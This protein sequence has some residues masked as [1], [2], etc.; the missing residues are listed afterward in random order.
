MLSELGF[1]NGDHARKW[2][3][4]AETVLC[5]D[6]WNKASG[7]WS[8]FG[9]LWGRMKWAG[10]AWG[11]GRLGKKCEQLIGGNLLCVFDSPAQLSAAQS[12]PG[13]RE[14]TRY[15]SWRPGEYQHMLVLLRASWPALR[16]PQVGTQQGGAVQSLGKRCRREGQEW[17]DRL[18]LQ[19]C[20]SVLAPSAFCL[21]DEGDVFSF[22]LAINTA[23][24]YSS[25]QGKQK[26]FTF[27][28][29]RSKNKNAQISILPKE[30]CILSCSLYVLSKIHVHHQQLQDSTPGMAAFQWWNH[31]GMCFSSKH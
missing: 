24:K 1:S 25:S 3:G 26:S 27:L 6:S 5:Q 23:E 20:P 10:K 15:H 12:S 8:V 22:P 17:Q 19:R 13:G 16:V 7:I 9:L 31:A 2:L 11:E 4:I 28:G 30:W 18:L 14:G 29:T 21:S